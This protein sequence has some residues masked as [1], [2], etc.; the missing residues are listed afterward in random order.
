MRVW[1][2]MKGKRILAGKK[3]FF[4]TLSAYFLISLLIL[5]LFVETGVS[6]GENT[7]AS[8]VYDLS[9]SVELS[10]K[11]IILFYY[12]LNIEIV[13]DPDGYVNVSFNE[14]ISRNKNDWGEEFSEKIDKFKTFVESED[15]HVKLDVSLLKDKELPLVVQ[16]Y[17]FT[18][19]RSWATGQVTLSV[20][21]EG[22]NSSGYEV[23][24]DSG[25]TTIDKVQSN[26]RQPGSFLFRVV[27]SD[28]LGNNFVEQS[29]VDPSRNHQVQ[30]FFVGGNKVMIDLKDNLLEIW[31]NN[32][33]EIDVTTKI[34]RLS[35]TSEKVKID[36]FK[37]AINV[38]ISDTERVSGISISE[39]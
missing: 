29:Y 17:N 18:Y 4:F 7:L 9:N 21:E 25:T 26:F 15:E 31:T 27:A 39:E 23:T 5:A 3:G 37:G 2:R 10:I 13:R 6:T 8:R 1:K 11:K 38:S 20:S 32:D 36:L 22:V 14:K 16:P 19:S 12:D 34:I 28:D 33:N 24:V 30:I 35:P